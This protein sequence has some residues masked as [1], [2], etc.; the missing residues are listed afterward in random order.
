MTDLECWCF[1]CIT[2]T[3]G[4]LLSYVVLLVK[5]EYSR[6]LQQNQTKPDSKMKIKEPNKER[7]IFI[8]VFL[9]SLVAGG[10]ALFNVYF[11]IFSITSN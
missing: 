9:F 11:W 7:D 2:C 3:F 10:F 8:E 6:Q 5:I 4:A 1:A